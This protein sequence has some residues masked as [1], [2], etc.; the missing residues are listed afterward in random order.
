MTVQ[1]VA[2]VD[3]VD[4]SLFAVDDEGHV[5]LVGARCGRCATVTFPAQ[6]GCPRCGASGMEP[7]K[8][9]RTGTVWAFTVQGFEPKSPYRGL[10]EFEPYGLGYVDLGPVRVESRLTV[11]DPAALHNGDTMTL[12]LVPAYRDDEGRVVHTFAF[13]PENRE[14]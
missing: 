12:R 2:G 9:P 4:E 14:D 6:E 3:V 10:G 8:L 7:E 1:E 13:G 5:C 11:N